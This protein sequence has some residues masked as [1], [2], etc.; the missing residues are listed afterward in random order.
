MDRTHRARAYSSTIAGKS[1]TN[2]VKRTCTFEEKAVNNKDRCLE[3]KCVKRGID[4]F[5]GQEEIKKSTK[6][7]RTR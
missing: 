6:A 3:I 2:R 4:R 1:T 5:R 7:E